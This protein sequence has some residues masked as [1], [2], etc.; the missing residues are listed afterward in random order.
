MGEMIKYGI[1]LAITISAAIALVAALVVLY[2][3]I[4]T[5]IS[6]LTVVSAV[7]EIFGA[8]SI[9]CPFDIKAIM[10]SVTSLMA[11]KIAYW[12][13]DKLIELNSSTS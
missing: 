1:K 3:L 6:G 10:L 8:I 13:A 9:L 2:N 7:S 11:F 4:T 5:A 12:V